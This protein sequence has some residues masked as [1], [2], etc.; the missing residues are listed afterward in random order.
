MIEVYKLSHVLYDE[1]VTVNI[2]RQH[3]TRLLQGASIQLAKGKV[4]EGLTKVFVQMPC[5]RTLE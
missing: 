5:D 3:Q 1:E 2:S 4:P